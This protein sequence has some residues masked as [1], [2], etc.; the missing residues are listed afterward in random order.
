MS[1]TNF[2]HLHI[3]FSVDICIYF[4]WVKC[5]CV[6]LLGRRIGLL[7]FFFLGLLIFIRNGQT[8]FP[9]SLTISVKNS[10]NFSVEFQTKKTIQVLES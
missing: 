10:V 8:I 7:F 3:G 9:S 5:L 1:E 4:G 2:E 6:E